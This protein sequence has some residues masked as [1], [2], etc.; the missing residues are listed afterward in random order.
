MASVFDVAKYIL[1]IKGKM[2]TWKLQKLCYYCQA[3]HLA[4]TGEELFP[5]DF[6]A[7][8]NGPVCQELF[9]EHRGHF[10][11]DENEIGKGDAGNLKENE[12]ESVITVLNDYGEM[13]P[14][15]LREQT[16][17]EQPW[18]IARGDLPES[19]PS[20]AIITKES[21]GEYYGGL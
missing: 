10:F 8:R 12:I 17:G 13:E 2:S 5:E 1:H 11:V 9:N 15:E 20:N 7:W 19:A 14:Y 3:W 18:I 6:Q 21:M 4:W 16:H